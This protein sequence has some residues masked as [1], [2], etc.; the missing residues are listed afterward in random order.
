[1]ADDGMSAP[2][3]PTAV[4][5][6]FNAPSKLLYACKL[7]RK[8]Q[9]M[10]MP[11]VVLGAND[12]LTALSRKLWSFGGEAEFWAHSSDGADAAVQQRSPTVLRSHLEGGLPHT[13]VLLNLGDDMPE[14]FAQFE[15]VIEVVSADDETDRQLAR[16]RWRGY[17]A[18]GYAI[19]RRDL[20]MRAEG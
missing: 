7:V 6:H 1:M 3:T 9:R 4:A 17:V 14:G 11:L 10:Q 18:Q 8:L 19:E 16:Q 13:R 2:T 20:E 15:R 12:T 5:F